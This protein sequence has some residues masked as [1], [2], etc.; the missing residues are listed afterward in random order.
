MNGLHDFMVRIAMLVRL[1]A[2]AVSTEYGLILTLLVLVTILAI[3]AIGAIGVQVS[4][5]FERG[6][7]GFP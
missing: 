3:G 4:G 6:S 1:E 7:T 5:L 2:G